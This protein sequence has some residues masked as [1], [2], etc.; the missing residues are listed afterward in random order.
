MLGGKRGGGKQA[1]PA[2]GGAAGGAEAGAAT[3]DVLGDLGK[4]RKAPR[5]TFKERSLLDTRGLYKL[6]Q[7]M[8]KLPLSRKPGNEVRQPRQPP[9]SACAHPVHSFSQQHHPSPHL[10]ITHRLRTCCA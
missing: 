8:Q 3:D 1:K 9:A 5:R 6:Y 7:E 2:V 10:L 4:K